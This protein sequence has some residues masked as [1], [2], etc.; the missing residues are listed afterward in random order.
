MLER[1]DGVFREDDVVVA[2]QLLVLLFTRDVD[3]LF[4][5]QRPRFKQSWSS[6][7]REIWRSTNE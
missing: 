1:L 5:S 4:I 7:P 2:L 6:G 3:V